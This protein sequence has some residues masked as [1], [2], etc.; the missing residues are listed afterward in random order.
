MLHK[1]SNINELPTTA[2]RV[3]HPY[4]SQLPTTKFFAT[5]RA[6][7]EPRASN[8]RIKS[9]PSSIN[10]QNSL[11]K[12]WAT[13]KHVWSLQQRSRTVPN[14]DCEMVNPIPAPY[15]QPPLD[16]D[17][18]ERRCSAACRL[19]QHVGSEA[20][21]GSSHENEY[22]RPAQPAKIGFGYAPSSL[23]C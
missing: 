21:F 8:C 18:S 13:P 14:P 16:R 2:H 3:E 5:S 1:D 20:A 15:R 6:R 17:K 9:P 7:I 4:C 10:G 23:I 12:D 22:P 11:I 19:E